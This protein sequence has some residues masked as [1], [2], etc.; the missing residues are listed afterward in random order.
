[1]SCCWLWVFVDD[2][3]FCRGNCGGLLSIVN[4]GFVLHV[5]FQEINDMNMLVEILMELVE[6]AIN[7]EE[8]KL[9]FFCTMIVMVGLYYVDFQKRRD[10]H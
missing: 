9:M 6:L 7:Y 4:G 5:D 1:M 2:S 3:G 8:V 10:T